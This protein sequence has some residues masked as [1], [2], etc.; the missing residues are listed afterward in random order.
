ML[1]YLAKG[2]RLTRGHPVAYLPQPRPRCLTSDPFIWP[3]HFSRASAAY[4]RIN[5]SLHCIYVAIR[6]HGHLVYG[7]FHSVHETQYPSLYQTLKPTH[8]VSA[9]QFHTMWYRNNHCHEKGSDLSSHFPVTLL[10]NQKEGTITTSCL[11]LHAD[12]SAYK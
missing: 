5:G 11:I 8:Q 1:L 2:D 3:A 6:V 4:A 12:A 9:Y 7:R 10:T